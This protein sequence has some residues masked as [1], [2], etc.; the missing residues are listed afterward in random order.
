MRSG[1]R[2]DVRWVG[3]NTKLR[4]LKY[5]NFQSALAAAGVFRFSKLSPEA[6]SHPFASAVG[7]IGAGRSA[8]AVQRY[9]KLPVLF[10][11]VVL[12]L[13]AQKNAWVLSPAR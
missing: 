7:E 2:A 10:D 9:C 12:R 8:G 4:C 1:R 6:S 11:C 3:L 13:R 5:Q